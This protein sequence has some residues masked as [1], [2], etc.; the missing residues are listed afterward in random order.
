MEIRRITPRAGAEISDIDLRD[1]ASR[2]DVERIRQAIVDAGVAV[3][4]DQT[5]TPEQ[6]IAFS[7]WF[8]DL[9]NY[10]AT[11]GEFLMPDYPDIVVISNIMRD[12]KP[13]G[14]RNAGQFWH[15]DRS[16]V[17]RPAWGSVLYA[18]TIPRAADGSPLGETLY[19]NML[20]VWD[21]LPESDR[22]LLAGRQ[23]WH[24]YVYRFTSR[25]AHERLPGVTHDI[26]LR[27]PISGRTALY[28]NKGFTHRIL[29]LPEEESQALLER[30]HQFSIDP[31]FLYT[32]RW[33]EGDV[34]I[35]DNFSTQHFA[36]NNYTPE[37][38]RL[39]WRTTISALPEHSI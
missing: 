1:P 10:G 38:P 18:R 23:A 6:L 26:A 14:A 8:G 36:V 19:A 4:R 20:S 29:G 16:Y 11:I 34:V 21:A 17:P 2:S 22:Q 15:T 25:A 33:N 27:H 31:R 5:L 24:E 7:R 9:E 30:L 32:H 28:L 13:I 37:Q 12:G 3:F 39:L 35:W